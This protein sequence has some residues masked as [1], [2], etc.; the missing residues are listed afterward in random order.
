[1][2]KIIKNKLSKKQ[3]EKL[4]DITKKNN[5]SHLGSAMSA[6]NI[7][8]VLM[9]EKNVFVGKPFGCQGLFIH[10]PEE[11]PVSV[12]T[13]KESFLFPEILYVDETLGTA[14][15]VALS[16]W[17]T[18]NEETNVFIPDS[19]FSIGEFYENLSY[20]QYL[21]E[22]ENKLI[23][24][25]DYNQYEI[26]KTYLNL[27]NLILRLKSFGF[28]KRTDIVFKIYDSSEE[29]YKEQYPHNFKFK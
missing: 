28:D 2:I 18:N 23:I 6:Y 8:L 26:S 19:Y 5:L 15:S 25:V 7:W 14:L 10:K 24:Y 17:E 27:D 29:K 21:Q 4:I 1:M 20:L 9:H 12:M 11:T 13:N 16:F 22:Q 3:L